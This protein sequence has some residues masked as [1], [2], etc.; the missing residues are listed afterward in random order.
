MREGLGVPGGPKPAP[1]V[2]CDG[3][4][5]GRCDPEAEAPRP[6]CAR[7]RGHRLHERTADAAPT[8]RRIDEHPDEHGP[9]SGRVLGKARREADPSTIPLGD[10]RHSF[11]PAGSARGPLIPDV[12]GE[13]LLPSQRGAE[14]HGGVGE[15]M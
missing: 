15:S 1:V 8:L 4:I 12:V 11:V 9:G 6:P 14:C 13:C 5:V 7:P 10:E 2:Q 3:R